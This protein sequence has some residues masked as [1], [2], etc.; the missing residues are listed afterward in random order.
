M[1]YSTPAESCDLR[2]PDNHLNETARLYEGFYPV[3][4]D[5]LN[6]E[7]HLSLLDDGSIAA[8][9]VFDNL[10]IDWVDEWDVDGLPLS[11]KPTIIAGYWRF[12]QFYTLADLRQLH[13]RD[14]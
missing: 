8:Q 9:H 13:G 1:L 10:P 14:A 3:F 7:T 2:T 6:N 4:R 12:G 11:L 5:V